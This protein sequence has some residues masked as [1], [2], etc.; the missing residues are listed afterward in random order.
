MLDRQTSSEFALVAR[1][2]KL[3]F[4]N[5]IFFSATAESRKSLLKELQHA[6]S[7]Q[8]PFEKIM[9]LNIVF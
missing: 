9:W 6:T 7:K 1:L 3:A 2:R 5:L 8:S 4:Q